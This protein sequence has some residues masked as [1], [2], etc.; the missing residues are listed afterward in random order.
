MFVAD[1][2]VAVAEQVVFAVSAAAA[3]AAAGWLAAAAGLLVAA[4]ESSAAFGLPPVP[5]PVRRVLASFEVPADREVAAEGRQA[6]KVQ[7]QRGFL[8]SIFHC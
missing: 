3:Q 8:E 5:A 7:E 2:T 4:V 6:G 1:S